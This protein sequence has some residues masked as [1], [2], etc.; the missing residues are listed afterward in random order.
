MGKSSKLYQGLSSVS[1]ILLWNFTHSFTF[2]ELIREQKAKKGSYLE[3]IRISQRSC[4][5]SFYKLLTIFTY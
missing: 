1:D 4:M 3:S 2:Q 5:V